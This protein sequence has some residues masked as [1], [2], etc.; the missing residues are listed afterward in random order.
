[1]VLPQRFLE[2]ADGGR[3]DCPQP[4]RVQLRHPLQPRAEGGSSGFGEDLAGPLG[5]RLRTV[6]SEDATAAGIGVIAVGEP[7]LAP[8]RLAY[9]R[10]RIHQGL[11]PA[12]Q[13]VGVSAALALHLHE[14]RPL[15]LGL[16]YAGGLAVEEEQIV[17]AAVPLLQAELPNGHAGPSA[18]IRLGS[19]LDDPAGGL[20]L[21]VDLDPCLGL[22]SQVGI[23]RASHG[24]R[25]A[26][27]GSLRVL[28]R[29]RR[30]G[31]PRRRRPRLRLAG[32]A[33]DEA[34]RSGQDL[35]AAATTLRKVLDQEPELSE[36]QRQALL[37]TRAS[38][39]EYRAAANEER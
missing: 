19:V 5:Q 18:H 39:A 16:D 28:T 27:T 37:E 14:G 35:Q 32:G 22:P 26:A 17:D 36:L 10:Q 30:W 25:V 21:P 7:G 15:G 3:L 2:V 31:R 33:L 12:G 8:R 23:V 29:A 9:E 6:E 24:H 38:L 13:P 34:K 11:A 4:R 20:Q 1:M